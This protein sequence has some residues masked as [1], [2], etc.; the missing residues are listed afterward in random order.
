M[1]ASSTEGSSSGWY[2]TVWWQSS[3]LS[4]FYGTACRSCRDKYWGAE[5][6]TG[7][8]AKEPIKHCIQLPHEVISIQEHFWK[9]PMVTLIRYYTHIRKNWKNGHHWSLDMQRSFVSLITSWWCEIVSER[10]D[11]NAL[12]TPEVLCMLIS[13]FS[14]GLMDNRGNRTV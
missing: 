7:K 4:L 9:E 6:K 13:N 8:T 11:W 2:G 5:R 10:Q 3:E 14:G 12:D 1:W